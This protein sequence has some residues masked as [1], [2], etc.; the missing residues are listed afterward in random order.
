[1]NADHNTPPPP[2]PLKDL[3][4]GQGF[5]D[6]RGEIRDDLPI[7][8]GNGLNVNNDPAHQKQ[9]AAEKDRLEKEKGIPK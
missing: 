5:S 3:K 4:I 6:V 2:R 7:P 1:M 8:K 9:K